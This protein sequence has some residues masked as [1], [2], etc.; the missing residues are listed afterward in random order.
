M[1]DRVPSRQ[2]QGKV[3]CY[4]PGQVDIVFPLFLSQT[5][6]FGPP[7]SNAGLHWLFSGYGKLLSG[8]RV[9]PYRQPLNLVGLETQTRCVINHTQKCTKT[10][11]EM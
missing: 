3:R 9:V 7:V 4:A 5:G 1:F 10:D 2:L 6:V 8:E 11:V